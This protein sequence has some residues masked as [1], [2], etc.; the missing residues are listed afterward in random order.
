[1]AAKRTTDAGTADQPRDPDL[2]E[3]TLAAVRGAEAAADA[4]LERDVWRP[5]VHLP[6][7]STIDS[8]WPNIS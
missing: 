4:Y 3:L 7:V 5:R 2:W 6:T 1:M 8:G